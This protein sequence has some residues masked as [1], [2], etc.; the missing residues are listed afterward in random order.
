M[1]EQTTNFTLEQLAILDAA[2]VQGVT[3]VTYATSAGGSKS[4]TYRSL[5][6]ML[7][8]RDIMRK[9]LGLQTKATNVHPAFSK[10]LC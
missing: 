9:E 8:I 3:T 10:G 1:S 5:S 4:V 7:R 6:E 2:I